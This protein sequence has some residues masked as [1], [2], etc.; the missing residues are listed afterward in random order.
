MP[1]SYDTGT[2]TQPDAGSVG[3]AMVE[4]IRDQIVAH[5]AW[6]LADEFTAASGTC[7]WYVFK[8]LAAG[9][10]LPN[11]FYVV[12]GRILGNGELRV[13]ICESYN[14]TT[15]VMQYYPAYGFTQTVTPIDSQ[16]RWTATYTLGA[17]IFPNNITRNHSWIPSGT[18]TK[19]W[20]I[21]SDDVVALAFN[22]A[23]NGWIQVGAFTPL[24]DLAFPM[25]L[26]VS[27]LSDTEY[28]IT[29]NPALPPVTSFT[30]SS[31]TAQSVAIGFTGDLRYADKLNE[32]QRVVSEIGLVVRV[33]NVNDQA[34][35][36]YALGKQ[37]LQ[38][39]GSSAPAGMIFGDGYVVE[40]RLWVP[41]LP[42]DSKMWDTGVAA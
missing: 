30:G 33:W 21:V 5:S 34:V 38:R 39:F 29:R 25:P 24:T 22:G 28:G 26:I 12:I 36:G 40:G 11:D 37:K 3:L 42:T 23:A 35:A 8:C 14:S 16:G 7:R 17:A 32:N 19:Y 4:R 31:L 18:S 1:I 20:I 2:I 13:A 27:G 15:K 41:Y 6:E 10:G 9:S